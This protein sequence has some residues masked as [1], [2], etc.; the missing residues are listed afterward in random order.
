MMRNYPILKVLQGAVL[1]CL[2]VACSSEKEEMSLIDDIETEDP[3]NEISTDHQSENGTVENATENNETEKKS[4][5]Q[6]D[7]STKTT[8]TSMQAADTNKSVVNNDTVDTDKDSVDSSTQIE[9]ETELQDDFESEMDTDPGGNIVG[10]WGM[11]TVSATITENVPIIGKAWSSLRTW[12]ISDI[13][14]DGNGNLTITEY[15]C[16]S[17]DKTSADEASFTIPDSLWE[18]MKPETRRVSVSSGMNGDAF[19]SDIQY[20]TR[21]L[22]MCDPST[23]TLPNP[24]GKR[25]DATPC[26]EP[27][28]KTHCDEDKD[29][30]P[31][32]TI[33]GRIALIGECDAYIS[34]YSVSKLEGE[35]VDNNTIAGALTNIAGA[36]VVHDA[37]NPLCISNETRILEDGCRGH[38]Y[39]KMIRLKDDATCDDVMALTDCDEKPDS[40]DSNE[41]QPLDPNMDTQDCV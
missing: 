12:Y 15:G 2:N 20:A 36:Q 1:L 33:K 9:N 25:N 34:A 38:Q 7:T 31:G 13:V 37:T 27:C 16:A 28:T 11:L 41:K 22:N 6:K 14:S 17:R 3:V 35:I 32:V 8:D 26:D 40:C 23:E 19:H 10:T 18:K 5:K 4:S 29:G 39:F 21:G 24:L 30:H